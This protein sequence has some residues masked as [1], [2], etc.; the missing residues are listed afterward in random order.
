VGLLKLLLYIPERS[1]QQTRRF[2]AASIAQALSIRRARVSA[3]L[4]VVI[5][6][7]QSVRAMGVMSDHNARAF[8]AVSRAFRR[9]AGILGSGT[10]CAGVISSTT[11][12]PTSAPA[13][14]RNFRLTL[15]Q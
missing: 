12:S 4:A 7:I 10:F 8:G 9:S 5:Q 14:S 3:R 2:P 11:T 6:C 13:D 15:S 1:K